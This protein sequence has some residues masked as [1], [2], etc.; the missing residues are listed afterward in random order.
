VHSSS[1]T[2]LIHYIKEL[3]NLIMTINFVLAYERKEKDHDPL[4][5]ILRILIAA[6]AENIEPV[7]TGTINFTLEIQDK[8]DE[9]FWVLD[10]L[11]QELEKAAYVKIYNYGITKG[12]GKVYKLNVISNEYSIFKGNSFELARKS[13]IGNVKSF[14]GHYKKLLKTS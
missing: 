1:R 6:E 3:K 5:D 4:T 14:R 2:K 7:L 13:A 9:L 10:V 11:T 8:S 12:S